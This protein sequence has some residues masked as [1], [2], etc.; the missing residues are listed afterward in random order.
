M[1]AGLQGYEYQ[2]E[3]A[4]RYHSEGKAEGKAEGRLEGRVEGRL[5]A[6]IEIV[7]MLLAANGIEITPAGR[8]RITDCT[9]IE[10][11]ESWAIRAGT[12]GRIEELFD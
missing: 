7:L 8:R 4:R 3:F 12:I 11:I 6:G 10:Q 1:T 9:D 2:T 5:E